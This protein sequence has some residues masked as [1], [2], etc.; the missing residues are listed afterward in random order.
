MKSASQLDELIMVQRL[1]DG[2]VHVGE[3]KRALDFHV[4]LNLNTAG[5][6]T[7]KFLGHQGRVNPPH[8]LK[9]GVYGYGRLLR[10][11]RSLPT[12]GIVKVSTCRT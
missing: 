2:A 5:L 4:P 3:I 1:K 9:P 11:S 7:E 12:K 8:P 6:P 10:L